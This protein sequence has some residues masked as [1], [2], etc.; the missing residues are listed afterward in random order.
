MPIVTANIHG[1]AISPTDLVSPRADSAN[2]DA[3]CA[4]ESSEAPAQ[5][6]S[7]IASQNSGTLSR[8]RIRIPLP[9]STGCSMG[10]TEKL[11]MF[12]SGIIAQIQESHFQFSMPKT[13]KNSVEMSMTP[14]EPQQ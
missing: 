4:I 9:S 14:T 10:H 5:T 8:S 11:Y 1:P 3:H 6:I 12:T 13:V 7:S 2:A